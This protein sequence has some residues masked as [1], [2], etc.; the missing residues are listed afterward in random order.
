MT[1]LPIPFRA[2]KGVTLS[3]GGT[4]LVNC[5]A[6][7]RT[8][9][10]KGPFSLVPVP[11]L[12]VFGS[13]IS[14]KCRGMI[15]LVDEERLYGVNG[16]YLYEIASDGTKTNKGL[17]AGTGKIWMARNDR[18][19]P[20]MVVVSER[21]V[22]VL[23]ANK[24]LAL[25]S[26]TLDNAYWVKTGTTV[27]IN[28][29]NAPT[30]ALTADR[31]TESSATSEHYIGSGS[32]TVEAGTIYTASAYFK[33][34]TT[35]PRNYAYLRVRL[36]GGS[37]IAVMVYLVD[38]TVTDVA[39]NPI[40]SQA[41][42]S[43]NGFWRVSFS[44]E[45]KTNESCEVHLGL[46]GGS[47]Y[48]AVSYLGD[49][50]SRVWAWGA[51]LEPGDE[52][53]A[54]LPTVA[55]AVER[56]LEGE[57][58]FDAMRPD[59]VV[60][61]G[62]YFIFWLASGRIYAS[63]LLSTEIN[64]LN[65]ATAEA[66]PDGITFCHV[67]GRNLFIVGPSVTEVWA[68]DGTSDFPMA[69]LGSATLQIGSEAAGSAQDFDDGFAFVGNDNQVHVI[70]GFGDQVI[71]TPEVSRLIEGE[72]DK[73]AIIGYTWR[74]GENEFYGLH[75]TGWT[76]EFNA[77][78]GFWH[79]RETYNRDQFMGAYHASAHGL[80]IWGDI[81]TGNH[82]TASNSVYAD[83]GSTLKWQFETQIS[84]AF[85]SGISF[86]RLDMDAEVGD[87]IS[88]TDDGVVMLDWSDDEGRSWKG[89]RVLSLGVQGA[90]NTRIRANRLG[91]SKS[92]GRKFRVTIT[93]AVV[94]AI[95]LVDV[96]AEAVDL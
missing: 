28:E 91:T 60:Q 4:R 42:L 95:N 76:M 86:N 11:G 40:G 83:L 66:S 70:K 5:Y 59:G 67:L 15:Y 12:T 61:I 41:V 18:T 33:R 24:N 45:T 48:S 44:F 94:R 13:E 47:V 62:G 37:K 32:I 39:G 29:T 72:A 53:S 9:D 78:T 46:L 21:Q 22:K 73:S 93:D 14:G 23:Q 50:T 6:E 79:H 74:R 26:E 55:A 77:R 7:Q 96:N 90:Y 56:D 65:F 69:P 30:G 82:Y 31:I 71:S 92:K 19:I 84:H 64:A 63:D 27:T 17:V 2:S 54:Y 1:A 68:I 52:A 16:F 81:E 38:G 34:T 20:Q 43:N 58:Y 3:E 36:A 49:N 25:Q 88:S 8:E 57:V 10:S 89:S 75:G 85:P 35:S 51:Q 80:E 87:G